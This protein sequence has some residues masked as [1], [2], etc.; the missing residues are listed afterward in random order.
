MGLA[1]EIQQ[2][3]LAKTLGCSS[4]KNLVKAC[5]VTLLRVLSITAGLNKLVLEL[6]WEHILVI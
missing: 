3:C 6:V 1:V 2:N 4:S 5:M